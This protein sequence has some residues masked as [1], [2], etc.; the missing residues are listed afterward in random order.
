MCCSQILIGCA[1][2]DFLAHVDLFCVCLENLTG[3]IVLRQGLQI[4]RPAN[5]RTCKSKDQQ[6]A[7]ALMRLEC[8]FRTQAVRSIAAYRRPGSFACTHAKSGWYCNEIGRAAPREISYDAYATWNAIM[9][10]ASAGQVVKFST[11]LVPLRDRL[12]YLREAYGH[13]IARLD[14]EQY[15]KLPL[16]WAASLHAFDGL[17]VTS[18]RTNGHIS[19]RT[20]LLLGDGNDDFVFTTNV[21]GFSVPSQIGRECQLDTGAA[22]LLSSSDIGA[23]AFPVPAEF[24]T[25]RI[26][27]Q[28]L[29]AT[30]VKPEDAL[31]RP[32][33]ANTEA[34]RLLVDYVRLTLQSHPLID[35]ELRWRFT[36]H[37]HD[38]VALALGATRDASEM[39]RARGLPAARLS[40]IKADIL[41]RLEEEGMT[42]TTIAKRRGVTP[43][44]VQMLFESDGTTFSE[45]VLDQRLAR[46]YRMLTEPGRIHRTVSAIAF[47]VGFGNLSYF[48]RV[49]RNRFG[50]TPSDARRDAAA[51]SEK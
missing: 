26:P 38:L 30:A 6:A 11:D 34:V 31:A 22:M 5:P 13:W 10:T 21:S 4:P 50:V 42:V 32:I 51:Y 3:T 18:G 48:N 25:L 40:A 28:L 47:Q 29:N 12:P 37:V 24:L 49:F 36:T 35:P 44:Y 7:R 19:R 14:L 41:G 23:Q 45:Y 20:R 17:C 9:A 16:R 2:I 15:A 8:D 39:A 46:S 33:A 1:A 27:R 43:R